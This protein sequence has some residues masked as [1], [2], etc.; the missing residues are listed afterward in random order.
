MYR[1]RATLA[2][3]MD[4]FRL[5][6]SSCEI[7]PQNNCNT[8]DENLDSAIS[9]TGSAFLSQEIILLP[10]RAVILMTASCLRRDSPLELFHWPSRPP[11]FDLKS[12]ISHQ[13]SSLKYCL[14]L[15]LNLYCCSFC[16]LLQLQI[17][18]IMRYSVQGNADENK[19][20]IFVY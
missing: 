11:S 17:M 9:H 20:V 6:S 2:G 15:F 18:H 14:H 16:F 5:R 10:F 7:G 4:L 19:D 12:F 1:S 3:A 13:P 8:S